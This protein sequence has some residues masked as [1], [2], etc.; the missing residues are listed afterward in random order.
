MNR[1]DKH[2]II[3]RYIQRFKKYGV[4]IKTLASGS[5]EHQ[6]IRFKIFSEIGD[7]NQHSILDIGCGFGD[8]YQYLKDNNIKVDYTGIDI[9]PVFI[10]VCRKRF[11]EA[12]FEV[13]DIQKDNITKSFDYVISSQ[14][15][16]NK[17]KYENNEIIIRDV[18][19]KSYEICNIAVAIDMLSNYVDFKEKHLYYYSPEEIFRFC[20]T[21]TKRVLLRH[22][23]PLF[24]FLI[25]LYK[26][27]EGWRKK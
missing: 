12:H 9:C 26:D 2:L 18:I 17:L 14:T 6:L 8:F 20:K 24:E 10:D 7:L 22:D 4:D 15:F 11:P 5:R 3:N 19:K 27:F 1:F 13:I 23:Y 16:N 25:C 21:L